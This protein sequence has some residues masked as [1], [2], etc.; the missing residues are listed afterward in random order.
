MKDDIYIKDKTLFI[1]KESE[2]VLVTKTHITLMK[3]FLHTTIN[4]DDIEPFRGISF[5][6]N[7]GNITID[8][9]ITSISFVDSKVDTFKVRESDT[10]TTR[11]YINL[12][13]TQ[14][15]IISSLQNDLSISTHNSGRKSEI[16]V[17]EVCNVSLSTARAFIGVLRC[18]RLCFFDDVN[19][20]IL[21]SCVDDGFVEHSLYNVNIRYYN[22]PNIIGKNYITLNRAKVVAFDKVKVSNIDSHVFSY[23]MS[24]MI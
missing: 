21:Y 5:T 2:Y 1:K 6:G 9:Y 24:R 18:K 8:S 4:F 10:Y 14:I 7:Y 12:C 15:G 17:I 16:E 22:H 23:I 20:G 19:I 13:N 11:K 3:Q